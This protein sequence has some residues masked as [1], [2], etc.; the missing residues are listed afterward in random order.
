MALEAVNPATG[1]KVKTYPEMTSDEVESRIYRAHQD[2]ANWKARAFSER[3]EL[4]KKAAQILRAGAN[5]YARLMAEE[6]GKPIKAGRRR[7]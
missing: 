4:M 3:A 7:S 1:E 2:F 5:E 6:M